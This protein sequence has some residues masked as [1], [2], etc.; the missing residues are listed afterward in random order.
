MNVKQ[1]LSERGVWFESVPHRATYD[2]QRMA[3]AVAV[4]GD[5][6][7]KTVVI[8]VDDRQVLAVLP[9]THQIDLAFVARAV[10][11]KKVTLAQEDELTRL[12]GDCEL[13]A[14][15]PFGSQYGLRTI[16]D[17]RLAR[18]EEIVFEGNTHEEAIRM[19][20]RD[21]AS[22]EHPLLATFSHHT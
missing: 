16:V 1:F 17:E 7:A 5:E 19:R 12:F 6:V 14:V 22:I 21:F 9:A 10:G 20:Y 3:Q 8:N 13:G 15:P 11:G 2:A 4:S 18:D